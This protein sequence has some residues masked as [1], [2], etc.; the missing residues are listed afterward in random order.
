MLGLVFRTSCAPP[1]TAFRMNWL[2]RPD[3]NRESRVWNPTVCQLAYAPKLLVHVV[4]L[5]P[6]KSERPLDFEGDAFAAQPHMRT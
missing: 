3:L 1:R 5:A 6:T 2:G 4:G